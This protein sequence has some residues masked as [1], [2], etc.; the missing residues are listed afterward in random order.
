M[1]D[2]DAVMGRVKAALAPIADERSP[3]PDWDDDL[4]ICRAHPEFDDPWDLFAHRIELVHG[5][6][7]RG[8]EA[9]AEILREAGCKRGFC[10][11]AYAESPALSE[12]DLE[13]TLDPA[14]V[15][16]YEFG[17]TRT[18]AAIAE[19]GTIVLH[20]RG[21]SRL[22][23]LAP[24]IHIAVVERANLLPDIP[25]AI[26]RFG[27]DPYIVFATGPSKTADVE[28]ILIEGVHGPGVQVACLLES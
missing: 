2:R 8:L 22:G 21:S 18:A 17:V 3:L 14:R 12:F 15:D 23:G 9:V 11:P 24:W 10:D 5:N 1:N 6:A 28:G 16:D 27:D 4:V 13:T 26:A 20:D 7:V 25:S 19:S